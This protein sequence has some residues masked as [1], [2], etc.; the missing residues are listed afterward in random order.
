MAKAIRQID[1]RRECV[2]SIWCAK[3]AG[4][5][6]ADKV[7]EFIG[8]PPQAKTLHFSIYAS[9]PKRTCYKVRV[10]WRYDIEIDGITMH[11]YPFTWYFIQRLSEKNHRKP[12]YVVAEWS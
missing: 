12:L 11:M 2:D 6:C 5:L 9:N 8:F 3:G 4:C 7:T 10:P 1:F